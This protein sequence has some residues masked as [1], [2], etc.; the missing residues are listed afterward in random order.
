MV[1]VMILTNRKQRTWIDTTLSNWRQIKVGVPQGSILGPLLFNIFINDIFLFVKHT[2]TTNYA[3]DNTP[4][5]Y[6][7]N[8]DN[9]IKGLE[10]DANILINWF[11][12]NLLKINAQKS[13]VF[14]VPEKKQSTY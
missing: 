4:Y 5:L 1:S 12:N 11:N 14:M 8:A 9:V 3:D 6:R 7:N 13:H 2:K 10:Y